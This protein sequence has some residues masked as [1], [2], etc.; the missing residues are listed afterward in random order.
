MLTVS[1]WN[2]KKKHILAEVAEYING[3]LLFSCW[4]SGSGPILQFLTP[5]GKIWVH[6][7]FIRGLQVHVCLLE[8]VLRRS[9]CDAVAVSFC[10]NFWS[11]EGTSSS[12]CPSSETTHDLESYRDC[13]LNVSWSEQ[14]WNMLRIL[15]VAPIVALVCLQQCVHAARSTRRDD[16][17]QDRRH[18]ACYYQRPINAQIRKKNHVKRRVLCYWI[19]LDFLIQ[20]I[21]IITVEK[22]TVKRGNT[23]EDIAFSVT[24]GII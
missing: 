4:A 5:L 7:L 18:G 10:L 8:S 24:F 1:T 22:Q 15:L 21:L 11:A 9:R 17:D 12:W 3:A 2:R 23:F 16:D 13:W 19:V 20:N 6:D 14:A